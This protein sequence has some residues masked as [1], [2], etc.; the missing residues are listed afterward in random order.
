MNNQQHIELMN[1]VVDGFATPAEQAEL[2]TLLDS[3]PV[4]RQY[5]DSLVLA[6]AELAKSPRLT[7]PVALKQN[8][9]AEIGSLKRPVARRL[10]SEQDW[11]TSLSRLWQKSTSFH[12]VAGSVA[13]ATAVVLLVSLF[14]W[15]NQVPHNQL[16]GSLVKPSDGKAIVLSSGTISAGV[17][18][19]E[20]K[21]SRTG[22]T[23][24]VNVLTKSPDVATVTVGF[25][26]KDLVLSAVTA[27][28]NP[29]EP[30]VSGNQ[31]E[32]VST[33]GTTY[34]LVL[35]DTSGSIST[36]NISITDDNLTARQ[37]ISTGV[38]V[39]AE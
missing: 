14:S 29:I 15:N 32:F 11:L 1:R 16:Q 5:F 17:S 38:W 26:H 8:I 22:N 10:T 23:L 19:A 31:L 24:T 13:G 35:N 39:P 12:L 6:S 36:L 2:R 21:V 30:R 28:T 37:E 20:L 18:A 3:D 27:N 9:M 34:Q 7:S 4:A 33:P 25:D